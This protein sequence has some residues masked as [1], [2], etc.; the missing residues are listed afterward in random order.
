LNDAEKLYFIEK[1][2][3]KEMGNEGF[4]FRKFCGRYSIPRSTV[5]HWLERYEEGE[6]MHSACGRS[7]FMDSNCKLVT[8]TTI[9]GRQDDDDPMDTN[10]TDRL[11]VDQINANR[12][13]KNQI[14]IDP[15]SDTVKNYKVELDIH[16]V[17]PQ[18]TSQARFKACSDPRMSYAVTGC[19]F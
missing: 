5:Q 1:I 15:H 13:R 12:K 18:K 14:P 10:E 16:D 19:R 2:Y 8:Q 9:K 17:K 11:I 4:S 7:S 6:Y 3:K